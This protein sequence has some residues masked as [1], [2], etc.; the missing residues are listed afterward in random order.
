M[1]DP[2]AQQ[3]GSLRFG[4]GPDPL[5]SEPFIGSVQDRA[6][7]MITTTTGERRWWLAGLG[8]QD[9]R[10]LF[11]P[12]ALPA[13]FPPKCFLNGPD[14]V[15]C[16]ASGEPDAAWVVDAKTGSVLYQGPTDLSLNPGHLGVEQVGDY[17]I[18]GKMD[19]GIYGI[20][21]TANTTWF[22]PGD[23]RVGNGIGW[24]NVAPQVLATQ[25]TGGR[26]SDRMVVFS[27]HD[28]KVLDYG[29]T[30]DLMPMSAVVYPGGFAVEVAP[31]SPAPTP[32]A[33]WFFDTSGKRLG[34]S[35]AS[36]SLDTL[37]Q[38]LP[39]TYSA[40]RATVYSNEGYPLAR[41][42]GFDPGWGVLLLGTRLFVNQSKS[43]SG[44]QWQE[45]DLDT[46]EKGQICETNLSGLVGSDG[47]TAVFDSG[48]PAIGRKTRGVDIATCTERWSHTSAVGSFRDVWRAGTTLVQLS[49]DGTELTS[50]V[51][52]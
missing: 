4:E 37:T 24:T 45:Y 19:E 46:G 49:D 7:F 2:V 40:R 17:A 3:T 30:D 13:A 26:G 42:T 5:W 44:D 35:V 6:Y 25:V 21:D 39:I 22:V 8:A 47:R 9:G 16:I 33:L 27:L 11:A 41:I 14:R 52:P 29:L 28:G 10:P 12:L 23:G 50:L 48:T 18:A 1:A 15:L 36:G 51:A 32:S 34:Q 38:D 43:Q 20:G 31:K